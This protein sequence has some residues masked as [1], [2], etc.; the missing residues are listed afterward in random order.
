ME[1]IYKQLTELFEQDEELFNRTIEEL[2]GWNGYLNDNRYYSMDELNEFFCNVEPL[3]MLSRAFYGYDEC[4]HVD[5]SG[6]K[7]YSEFNPNRE[8]FSFN[9]YGNLVSSDYKDYSYLLDDY[10]IEAL[11]DNKDNLYLDD[12][13]LEIIDGA[14]EDDNE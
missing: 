3:E 4:Y 14:E 1:T 10:F 11:I 8:Y 9:G 6:N 7:I 13:I 2:D 5:S 12:E